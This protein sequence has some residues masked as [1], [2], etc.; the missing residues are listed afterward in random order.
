MKGFDSII[1]FYQFTNQTNILESKS[2][3]NLMLTVF[4][5]NDALMRPGIQKQ[6]F[7]NILDY[8]KANILNLSAFDNVEMV[9]KKDA[10]E[11]TVIK[12]ISEIFTEE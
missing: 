4:T 10:S 3:N 1:A 2:N 11:V 8:S 6:I 7:Y 12:P 9:L 5:T